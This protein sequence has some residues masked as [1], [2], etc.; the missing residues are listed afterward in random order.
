V[1][2]L[3]VSDQKVVYETVPDWNVDWSFEKKAG[4]CGIN[5][6]DSGY[7]ICFGISNYGQN[8]YAIEYKLDSAVGGYTDKDGVNFRFVN[9]GM[10]TTPTDVKVEIRLADGRPITDEIAHVWG[11][12]CEGPFASVSPLTPLH[13][14]CYRSLL[15]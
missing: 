12:D 4:K 5:P 8:R 15:K 1:S 6:T 9:D 3:T 11:F 13:L 14:S 7:E 2:Q 10:N